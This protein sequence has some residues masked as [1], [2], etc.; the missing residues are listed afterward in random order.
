M[1]NITKMPLSLHHVYLADGRFE[2][3][4]NYDPEAIFGFHATIESYEREDDLDPEREVIGSASAWVMTPCIPG[5]VMDHCD[6]L[7]Q[8]TY[9]VGAFLKQEEERENPHPSL[10]YPTRILYIAVVE[11]KPE[12]R[13]K[14][15]G[16]SALRE[17]ITTIGYGCEACVIFPSPTGKVAEDDREAITEKLRSHYSRAGFD[18]IRDTEYMVLNLTVKHDFLNDPWGSF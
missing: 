12:F 11:L 16:L 10:E 6:S 5:F 2:Q 18:R 15:R 4:E 17:L 7:R 8:D 3:T 9:E 1:T 14:D 13:G